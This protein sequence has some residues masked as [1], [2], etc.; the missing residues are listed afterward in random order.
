VRFAEGDTGTILLWA[1]IPVAMHLILLRYGHKNFYTI[2]DQASTQKA[3]AGSNRWEQLIASVPVVGPFWLLEWQLVSR[4]QRSKWNFYLTIPYATAFVLFLSFYGG[5]NMESFLLLFFLLAGGYGA[6]HLQHAF[7]WES[8][9]FDFLASRHISFYQ[10][11]RSRYLFYL[12]YAT[13]QMIVIIPILAFIDPGI[14]IAYLGLFLYACGFGYF[15]Y[16]FMGVGNSTRLDANGRS[17]FNME[18]VTGIKFLQVLILF[19][20]LLPFFLLGMLLPTEH[21][22]SILL[23]IT[24]IVFIATHPWWIKTISS[25]FEKMKYT[26]LNLYRQK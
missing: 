26:K 12:A 2:S 9:F 4:N 16:M 17:S 21:G 8:H 3:V 10:M 19:F 24:G 5:D 1:F 7:S 13:L 20:S 18:G 11:A 14:A 22:A 23:G 25:R 15:F 6:F